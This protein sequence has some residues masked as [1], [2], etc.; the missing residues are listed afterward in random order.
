MPSLRL[1]TT[2]SS[3]T[4]KTSASESAPLPDY[5]KYVAALDAK[6]RRHTHM[7]L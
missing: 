1:P 5:V 7:F 2:R 4:T 3:K 6:A